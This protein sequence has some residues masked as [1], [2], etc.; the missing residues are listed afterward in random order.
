M[1]S[2]LMVPRGEDKITVELTLKEAMALSGQQFHAS[3][4]L[5]PSA[6]RKVIEA[7]DRKLEVAE[8]A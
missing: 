6:T 2:E 5:K 7:I 3:P 4:E 8:R 1:K